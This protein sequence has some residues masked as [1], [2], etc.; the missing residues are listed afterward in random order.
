MLAESLE[1][2]TDEHEY[3][4]AGSNALHRKMPPS[5]ECDLMSAFDDYVKN[6]G[7]ERLS[8]NMSRIYDGWDFEVIG[9]SS[10]EYPVDNTI[11]C[12][13]DGSG[14]ENL[15]GRRYCVVIAGD[16]VRPERD[17]CKYNFFIHDENPE[18]EF[19]ELVK[20]MKG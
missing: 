14:L 16:G 5:V 11:M 6:R 8:F 19:A 1:A 15:K 20:L 10:I 9:V 2:W 3:I 7:I 18:A 13:A 12:A 4:P 17:I